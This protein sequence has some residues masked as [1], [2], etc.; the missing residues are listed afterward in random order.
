MAG[1][2]DRASALAHAVMRRPKD[3]AHPSRSS[4]ASRS[5]PSRAADAPHGKRRADL[6][7][8]EGFVA[9]D[10]DRAALALLLSLASLTA[11]RLLELAQ[12]R[13]NAAACLDGV[14]EGEVGSDADRRYAAKLDGAEI[15]SL[16]RAARARLV[17]VGDA[18]Y[19]AELLDLFDPPA[20]LFV[21]GAP[22]HA[23][24]S[25]RVAVVGARNC[26][27]A[28]TEIAAG[29]ARGLVGGGACV[30]SGGAR[31]IDTAAHRGALDEGGQT[32][33][34]LGCGID[35]A[36]PSQVRSLLDRAVKAGA[37]VSEYPP[38]VPAEPFRFPARNRIVAGLSSAVVVVEGGPG[39]GS[40][41]T[42]EHALDLGREV[43]AVPGPVTSELSHVPHVLIREG[44]TLVRGPEDVL[45]DLGLERG[46]AGA[47]FG[48]ADS[49]AAASSAEERA[50]L[51]AVT[52]PATA[53]QLA[54][55]S[56]LPLPS[57]I[58]ALLRL[59]VRGAVRCVGGRFERR[60]R[61]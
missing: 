6:C 33:V 9:S 13:M 21:R 14:L 53:D 4:P 24:S 55:I 18:E 50:V 31:G 25:P 27:P 43:F 36:Y 60:G 42:A 28:G 48:D 51:L 3:L 52:T 15:L 34:V 35:V 44:A 57:V 11:R 26:S 61:P 17:A 54:I 46:L 47:E 45:C 38:G 58:A 49:A 22:L 8:P 23:L 32:V 56:G 40:L 30:V 1:D 10:R 19:P 29:I 20:G 16:V 37:V 12:R 7:W 2:R 39:S 5:A 41:I 59:E